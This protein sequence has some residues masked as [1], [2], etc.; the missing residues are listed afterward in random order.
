MDEKSFVKLLEAVGKLNPIQFKELTKA[1]A[2]KNRLSEKAVWE[3]AVYGIAEQ[4]LIKAGVNSCCPDCGSI[5]VSCNGKSKA[6]IQV[7]LCKDCSNTFTRFSGTLLERSRYP[8][9]VWVEVLRMTLLDD[10]I[11]K[12]RNRLISDFGCTGISTET[13]FYMRLKLIY[14]MAAMPSPKLSGVIQADETVLYESQKGSKK[15]L[16][17]FIK[18]EERKPRVGRRPSKYG[19][20]GNEFATILTLVDSNGY[21]ICKFVC[22]GM[23][24]ADHVTDLFE[25]YCYIPSY[26][27]TDGNVIYSSYCN[28]RGIPHYVKPSAYNTNI[29]KVMLDKSSGKSP[30]EIS[31]HNSAAIDKLYKNKE[32]D[33]IEHREDLSYFEF[34]KIKKTYKLNLARVNELHSDIKLTLDK[35]MTNVATKYLPAYI[36]FF[37]FRRNWRVLEG[38]YP[39]S[40][41]DAEK[42]LEQLLLIKNIPT[43]DEFKAIVLDPPKATGRFM[44]ILKDNTEIVRK[45]TANKYF[46]FDTED[47]PSFNKREIL[48]DAPRVRLNEVAKSHGIKGYTKM[49][50]WTLVS[51]ILKL[52]N[53]EAI[54]VDLITKYRYY[55]IAEED[56]VYLKSLKFGEKKKD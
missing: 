28:A 47:V 1:Y 46:K 37:T 8:W 23:A 21:C 42:I 20:R 27:C 31:R 39:T 16:I 18:D 24:H 3:S 50:D 10:S 49:G 29:N 56:I 52:P 38:H 53:V 22:L 7:Y 2:T 44:Q 33:Y 6:G 34:Q 48:L 17:S 4:H 15:G 54:V 35:K 9:D 51:N 14:A 5:S 25:D 12:M 26:V 36:G 32:I 30:E 43:K 11:E 13:L 40:T 55:E 41:A 45:H 19:T